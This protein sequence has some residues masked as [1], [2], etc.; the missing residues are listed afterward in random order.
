MQIFLQGDQKIAFQGLSRQEQ[1]SKQIENK[2]DFF[3]DFERLVFS[4]DVETL[5]LGIRG[6]LWKKKTSKI[7]QILKVAVHGQHVFVS[8]VK[9]AF[10]ML[11]LEEQFER[12]VSEH[13]FW[14]LT[15]LP[16][17]RLRGHFA[18]SFSLK[19][20]NLNFHGHQAKNFPKDSKSVIH[21]SGR[22]Y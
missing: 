17:F 2:K 7:I 3:S 13:F 12:N 11:C 4:R 9:I 15:K 22:L 10:L 18:R 14:T 8:A 5:F 1:L 6:T 20:F 16:S 21:V 19:Y